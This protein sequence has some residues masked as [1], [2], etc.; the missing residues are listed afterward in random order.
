[1]A[2]RNLDSNELK[3]ANELLT[4]I[5]ERLAQLAAGDPLL[6]FAYRRKIF[7]E[8]GYDERGKPSVRNKLKAMK[9]GL[10]NGK[11]AHCGD[12][13]LLEYSEL[14]RKYAPDG[15]TVENTD[16]VHAKYHQTRQAEKR[17]T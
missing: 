7:K 14:D 12:D 5:R 13:M 15:Y 1:M 2:H 3:R 17:Y 6:L 10:Q 4:E 16:L 8:L 9:W 11:C